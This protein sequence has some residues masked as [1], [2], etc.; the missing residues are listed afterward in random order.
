MGFCN[1]MVCWDMTVGQQN[2]CGTFLIWTITLSTP[3]YN[4]IHGFCVDDRS[5]V[6][7]LCWLTGQLLELISS[8]KLWP[9]FC[10]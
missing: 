6:V 10:P 9:Y 8:N 2:E 4:Q 1:F 7:W 3:P 5:E